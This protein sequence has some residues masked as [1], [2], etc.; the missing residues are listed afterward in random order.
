MR[1]AAVKMMDPAELATKARL[2]ALPVLNVPVGAAGVIKAEFAAA[3]ATEVKLEAKPEAKIKLA[4]PLSGAA[5]KRIRVGKEAERKRAVDKLLQTRRADE[6]A[7]ADVAVASFE[8]EVQ[9]CAIAVI[10]AR[11]ECRRSSAQACLELMKKE[12]MAKRRRTRR[13]LRCLCDRREENMTLDE[14]LASVMLDEMLAVED[15][16]EMEIPTSQL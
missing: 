14:M 10:V 7:A 4:K 1:E 9:A 5:K 11:R 2:G 3:A 8:C 15:V 13:V 16:P 12:E 6:A